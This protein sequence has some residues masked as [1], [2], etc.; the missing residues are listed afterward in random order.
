MPGIYEKC[1]RRKID[2]KDAEWIADLLQH[3][4][5]RASYIPDREQLELRELSR[6]RKSLIEERACELNRLQKMLEGGNIKLASVLSNI[7]GKSARNLLTHMLKKI[8]P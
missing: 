6:Y 7:N 3:D 1:T 5:L 4:L 2:V 8:M